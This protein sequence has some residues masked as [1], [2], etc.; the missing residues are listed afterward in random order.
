MVIIINKADGLNLKSLHSH[1]YKSKAD[2]M[3]LFYCWLTINYK[4]NLSFG[5]ISWASFLLNT[6]FFIWP[7]GSPNLYFRYNWIHCISRRTSERF[8]C[9]LCRESFISFV[10][11]VLICSRSYLCITALYNKW[12]YRDGKGKSKRLFVLKEYHTFNIMLYMH[13]D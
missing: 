13:T 7:C 5:R 9:W 12:V 8:K 6:I 2:P 1:G 3:D 11:L 4:N 10:S